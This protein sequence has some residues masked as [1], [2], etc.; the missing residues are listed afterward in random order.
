MK[1]ECMFNPP[2]LMDLVYESKRPMVECNDYCSNMKRRNETGG[3]CRDCYY[4]RPYRKFDKDK[5]ESLPL[6]IY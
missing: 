2:V 4:F 3:G 1:G 6:R 5:D